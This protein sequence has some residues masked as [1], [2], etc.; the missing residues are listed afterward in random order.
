MKNTGA[1]A[2]GI[3]GIKELGKTTLKNVV[4]TAMQTN[5][6]TK[7]GTRTRLRTRICLPETNYSRIQ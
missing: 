7:D 4:R 2:G 3:W 5:E 1:L 6:V